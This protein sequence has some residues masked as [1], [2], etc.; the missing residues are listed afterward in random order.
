MELNTIAGISYFTVGFIL[1]LY[2]FKK[3][4]S[5]EYDELVKSDIPDRGITNLFL[6]G[7]WL[8]WPIYLVKNIIKYKR[9]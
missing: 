7:L 6:L 2:W 5:K 9:I 1:A 3:D 4:Y 8:F